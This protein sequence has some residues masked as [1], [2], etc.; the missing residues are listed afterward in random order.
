MMTGGNLVTKSGG[1][2]GYGDTEHSEKQVDYRSRLFNRQL[3]G[4][5]KRKAL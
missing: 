3:H 4:K 5:V 1:W 2:R